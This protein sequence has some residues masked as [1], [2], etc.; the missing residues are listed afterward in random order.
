MPPRFARPFPATV[1]VC[2]DLPMTPFADDLLD[3]F[4]T[5][6]PDQVLSVIGTTARAGDPDRALSLLERLDPA[7]QERMTR[8]MSSDHLRRWCETWWGVLDQSPAVVRWCTMPLNGAFADARKASRHLPWVWN[9]RPRPSDS[10]G[11]GPTPWSAW[12]ALGDEVA[13]RALMN[14]RCLRWTDKDTG[15]NGGVSW[16]TT[17]ME[18]AALSGDVPLMADLHARGAS[19]VVPCRRGDDTTPLIL[20]IWRAQKTG[21]TDP[22]RWLLDQGARW[23]QGWKNPATPGATTAP[24][25]WQHRV[26]SRPA[27]CAKAWAQGTP[28][29]L[30]LH[31]PGPVR[32]LALQAFST[33]DARA[34]RRCADASVY[35]DDPLWPLVE[36][37]LLRA[38][39]SRPSAPTP[40]SG[41]RR[42]L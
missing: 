22:M 8:G 9:H 34:R 15:W 21:D 36:G 18:I 25:H 6:L 10:P 35:R 24:F 17:P 19:L 11:P 4:L 31:E 20:A 39:L 7:M 40:E 16:M 28:W 30:A 41:V 38:S 27:T 32:E 29:D 26:W 13:N 14:E 1:P 33:M 23:D 12:W 3:A 42:R 2:E 5:H 37:A